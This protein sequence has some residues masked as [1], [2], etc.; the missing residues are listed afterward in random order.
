P[1][2]KFCG[3]TSL[4]D[5]ERAVSAGAWAVGLIFW[6]QSVRACELEAAAEI[7][8][9]EVF[10]TA[11]ERHRRLFAVNEASKTRLPLGVT[12]VLRVR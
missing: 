1:K 8:L 4:E 5:A 9:L 10:A 11:A 3:L 7:R 12:I 6:P 2:I